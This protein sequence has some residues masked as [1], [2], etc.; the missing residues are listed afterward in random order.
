MPPAKKKAVASP[1]TTA[2]STILAYLQEKNRPYSINDL[3]LN[4][5]NKHTKAVIQKTISTLVTKKHVTEKV[6]G[7]QTVY[8]ASQDNVEVPTPEELDEMD[9]TLASLK[10]EQELLSNQHKEL[11]SELQSLMARPTLS[12]LLERM[13]TLNLETESM[14]QRLIKFTSAQPESGSLL[15]DVAERRALDA[16]HTLLLKQ[17]K[18]R[19]RLVS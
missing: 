8:V 9:S 10:S 5:H 6:Y 3:V 17:E 2:E 18:Q 1:S 16:M 4:L 11:S 19:Q 15:I 14:T 13:E 12:M 7:K